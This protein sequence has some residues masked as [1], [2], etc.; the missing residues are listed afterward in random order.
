[1]TCT[2]SPVPLI[3]LSCFSKTPLIP[4]PRI[5]AVFFFFF[6]FLAFLV[7]RFPLLFGAFFQARVGGSG[8]RLSS[9]WGVQPTRSSLGIRSENGPDQLCTELSIQPQRDCSPSTMHHFLWLPTCCW[10]Q[11]CVLSG[12]IPHKRF[13]AQIP[14][15][16]LFWGF[17]LA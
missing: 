8:M 14:N 1:M 4:D 2:L 11:G 5:L 10:N 7:F 15:Q 13:T 6:D 16:I 3:R 9:W 17:P 12:K